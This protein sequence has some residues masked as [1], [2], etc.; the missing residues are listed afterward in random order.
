MTPKELCERLRRTESR[1]K[2][3]L[4]DEAADKIEALE[5]EIQSLKELVERLTILDEY[6]R[7]KRNADK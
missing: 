2:R 5:K 7:R 6:E 4:L 1:S 3:R